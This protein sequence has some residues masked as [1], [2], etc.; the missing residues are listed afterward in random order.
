MADL[1]W[2]ALLCN[3]LNTPN[4]RLQNANSGIGS[5]AHSTDPP[6]TRLHLVTSV[7]VHKVPKYGTK[8]PTLVKQSACGYCVW[9]TMQFTILMRF[10]TA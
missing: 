6:Q 5:C 4:R 3:H 10:A 8:V 9:C 1:H 2:S 7:M